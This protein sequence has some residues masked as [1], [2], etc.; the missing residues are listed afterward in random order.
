MR[1]LQL[2]AGEDAHRLPRRRLER[3]LHE[4]DVA[5]HFHGVLDDAADIALHH[6]EVL[7]GVARR[8]RVLAPVAQPDL[9]D[10]HARVG[11]HRPL[12]A[13]EQHEGAHRLAVDPRIDLAQLGAALGA[14]LDHPPDGGRK[15]EPADR[16][17][18]LERA[19]HRAAIGLQHHG[20]VRAP[21]SPA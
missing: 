15:S 1:P 5:A 6:H 21:G 10:Q 14:A 17:A 19:E 16:P 20:G 2:V 9:V 8:D 7:G 18:E 4:L 12:D 11:R 3:E 13:A